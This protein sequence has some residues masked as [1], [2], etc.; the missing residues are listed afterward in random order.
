M[1]M[2]LMSKGLWGA[3]AGDETT[4]EAKEQ[5]AHAAIVLNLSDSQLMHVIDSA[6]AR[7]AWGRKAQFHHSQDMANRLWLKEKFA[8]FTYTASS[9]GA[10]V[11]ELEDLVMKLKR[12]NCGPS[13]ED[14]CAVLLRSILPSIE[15][16]IQ[17]SACPSQPSTSVT[18]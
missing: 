4:S 7:D 8:S 18:S 5:Q 17:V 11:M 10:H 3:I 15:S 13:E 14:V 1:K 9:M 2:Y 12:A 6:S 16:L